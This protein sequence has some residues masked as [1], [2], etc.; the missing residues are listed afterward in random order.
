MKRRNALLA[1]SSGLWAH[2]AVAQVTANRLYRIGLFAVTARTADMAGPQPS[3][4]PSAAFVQG[5]A[6]LGY[7]YGVHYTTEPRGGEGQ[8][9]RYP[10][11]ATELA[12][13][14]LDALVAAGPAMRAVQRAGISA[15]VVMAGAEDPIGQGFVRSL[16]QPGGN[17][18]GLSN[19]SVD[20]VAKRLELL[21][22][23]VPGPAPLGILWDPGAIDSWKVADAAAR[24]RG[25]KL[26]SLQAA[27]A[28]EL[29][30]AMRQAAATRLGGLVVSGSL[31]LFEF[32]RVNA[33]AAAAR[34]PVVFS[35]RG[36]VVEGALMSYGADINDIWRR[37]AGFVDRILRGAKPG[38]LAVEQP[39]KFD[40]VVNLSA[41]R[42][43]GA[44][45]PQALLVRATEVIE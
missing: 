26:N 28:I 32:R 25:W 15:P 10:A 36:P 14:P 16:A 38:D 34:M 7:R 1:L 33:A 11:L 12:G 43:I 17:F 24:A 5:M 29:E 44:K 22:E 23:V 42:A 2:Q 30:D 45:L 37:A 9:E 18:T 41:A 6:G 27:N 40:L 19:Q 31:G 21:R 13:M 3:H 4:P 20:I 39:T 35:Q 8:V